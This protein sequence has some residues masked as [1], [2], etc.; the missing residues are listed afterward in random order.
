MLSRSGSTGHQRYPVAPTRSWFP[1]IGRH[2]APPP[3]ST[4]GSIV[5]Q[6][7]RPASLLMS[8]LT[9]A[10][11]FALIGLVLLVPVGLA[12]HAY[13][14]QQGAQIAFSAKERVGMVY[15]EP[16]NELVVKL[17]QARGAAV[18]GEEVPALDDAIA[19]VDA[20]E[21]TDG[22]AL[23]TTKLWTELKGTID[24]ASKSKGSGQAGFDAWA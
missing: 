14:T 4:D 19:A 20:A 18:R 10:R 1:L 12:L 5:F 15:L 11:K 6:L 2:T 3:F 17:V 13:W 23:E 24:K 22:K 21:E 8:R 7:F 16:A 9:Y